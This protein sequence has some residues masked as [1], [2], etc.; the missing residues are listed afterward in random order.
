[1]WVA[2]DRGLRLAEK[3]CLPCPNRAKWL[4]TRDDLYEEIQTKG[5]NA[6]KG[7]Y[8]Q[9]YEELDTLD[10]S[11]CECTEEQA[12]VVIMPLV[13]F[14]NASDPRFLSTLQHILK[15]P[16]KGGLTENSSVYRYNTNLADDGVGGEEG[17][18]SLC[19][20]WCVEAMTRA[21]VYD[22]QYLDKA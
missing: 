20:L 1:M 14:V 3:R 19:T 11:C 21:G 6:E 15:T 16:E 9:C 2:I 10:S 8:V 17:A 5:W 18:F 13:F 4:Q 7:H 22:R 12:D